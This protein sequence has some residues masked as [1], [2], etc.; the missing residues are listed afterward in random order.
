MN[1]LGNIFQVFPHIFNRPFI[2]IVLDTPLYQFSVYLAIGPEVYVDGLV[3]IERN[4]QQVVGRIGCKNILSHIFNNR[5]YQPKILIVP[6]LE[7]TFYF[8][9]LNARI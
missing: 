3:V 4:N 9:I 7:T 6:F 2:P 1:N 8:D 5:F